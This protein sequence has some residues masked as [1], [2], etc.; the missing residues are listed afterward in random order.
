[1][2]VLSWNVRGLR[3]WK[4]RATVKR[5]ITKIS[6]S[7]VTLEETKSSKLDQLV[8]K[9]IWSLRDIEWESLDAIRSSG[10]AASFTASS[11][12]KGTYSLCVLID[13]EKD[14][15][16]QEL[17]DLYCLMDEN[18]LIGGDFNLIR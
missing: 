5:L 12:T 3:S 9:S 14:H 2:L 18:W 17:D 16:I 4:K 15:F 1:M 10:D 6:S 7:I 13:S 11:I 8:I